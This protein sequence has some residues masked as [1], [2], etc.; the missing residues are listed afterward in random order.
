[1]LKLFSSIF[2]A[3]VALASCSQA[4]VVNATYN[5][6]A[7]IPV[8][9]S[10]YTATGNTV[11][12][13]LGFAPTAGTNLTV[14]NNT[15]L[16]FISGTFGN[17]MHGQA[18]TLSY[19]GATYPFVANYYG[20]TGNDLVLQWALQDLVT[21]GSN[22]E[23]ELGN[24]SNASNR[25]PGTV[26]ASGV[27]S[28]KTV[29]AIAAGSGPN[30]ALCSDGTLAAWGPNVFGN[31][32]NGTATNSNVPV[33][34]IQN[35]VLSGKTVIAIA[36]GYR[37]SVALCSDGTV[38]SW[39]EG[40]DGQLG[41]GGTSRQSQPV[42]VIRTGALSGKTVVAIAA[43]ARYSLAL[44]SD[45][46]LAGWGSNSSG[47]I[48][49]SAGYSTRVPVT[50]APVGALD[51][52]SV[53]A[54]AAG[55]SHSLA[56]CSDGT[57]AAWGYNDLGQ[58]GNGSFTRNS[59]VYIPAAVVRSGV[60]AGRTTVGIAA[61]DYH[62]FTWCSDGTI[63]AWGYN[64]DGEL[65]NGVSNYSSLMPVTVVQNG[66]LAGKTI[67]S[68]AGR[69]HNLALY[70]D[71]TLASW[72][73]NYS[74]QL[75]RSGSGL[76]PAAVTPN[77]ALAGK[78]VVSVAAGNSHSL[79]MA[80]FSAPVL[81]S[82]ATSTAI[83]DTAVTLGGNVASDGGRSITERGF[84]LSPT[85]VN[86]D[87]QIGGAGVITIK[88]SGT[89]GI[90]TLRVAD[91]AGA[92]GYSFKAY[93]TNSVGTTYTSPV[94]N[95]TTLAAD[96]S[97]SLSASPTPVPVG[98]DLTYSMTLT[99]NGPNPSGSPGVRLPLPAG[100]TFVSASAPSGWTI[101][102]PTV[103]TNGTV[104]FNAASLASGGSATFTVVAKVNLSDS[105]LSAT[106][107]SSESTTDPVP[108]NNSATTTAT[109]G[110][111]LV[112]SLSATPEP[113]IAGT[114][115][116]YILQVE[117]RGSLAVH[118]AALSFTLPAR[119][120]F[121]SLATS[122]GW[123]ATTPAVGATGTVSITNSLFAAAGNVSFPLV[124]KVGSDGDNGGVLNAALEASWTAN[125]PA[126]RN[127]RSSTVS[128]VSTVITRSD[129]AIKLTATPAIVK[130]GSDVNYTL[131]LTNNGPSDAVQ[132]FVSFPIPAQMTFV[133]AAIPVGW[134][135]TI[136]AIGSSGTVTF[137]KT[138][139][140]SG[141]VASFTIVAK[142][143]TATPTGTVLTTTAS[144]SATG[145]DPVTA[146]NNASA[147]VAVGTVKPTPLQLATTG[148]LNPQNGLYEL[149]VKVTNTTPLPINGFRLHV[150]FASYLTA[151]PS[152]RLH[153]ASSAAGSSDVY[154]NYPYAVA[155]D[156]VVPVKLSFYT[157]TRTFPKPFAP[158]LTV[159]ILPTSAV[160]HTNGTGVQPRFIR[161]NADN[162][163]IEF[164]SIPG[165]SYRVRYSH[166]LVHWFDCPV[167]ILAVNSRT[168]WIDNGAP[169]TCSPPSSVSSRYYRVNDITVPAP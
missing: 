160:A 133:T 128:T 156:G 141:S 31:L 64:S 22:G 167:P 115:L 152:L 83:A 84:V 68:I 78:T 6:A 21:W 149:T 32:G 39:G 72:G 134:T 62:S 140:T 46:T 125:D 20:G 143:R 36:A 7:T 108:G 27:L 81:A 122:N 79:V 17:L 142:V 41:D 14:I 88:A 30:M 44:C 28:G 124:V 148:T 99:N 5:T 87:P 54:I 70:T 34:V 100:T 18:V 120:T 43:G 51:G 49:S 145:I 112:A 89:T 168:Q 116:T 12:F 130:K 123:T 86:A 98:T 53:I 2:I 63:A 131:T 80:A 23:G 105:T 117:N 93:A 159:E 147:I 58:V 166:D 50:V 158:V 69:F 90:F 35:G 96:L 59:G 66:V 16:D 82:P 129:L 113:V 151:Y 138:G 94:S 75:G 38:A 24:G 45:G 109:T 56:L 1:M 8:V 52:K 169:F 55:A 73:Q 150:N 40:E 101:V 60:L 126:P 85:A 135:R 9:A 102:N 111:A 4:L 127:E 91:L 48:T 19:N 107:T 10:S 121:V 153:N 137:S 144:A 74:G 37:H 47:Q 164:P 118:N 57:L 157:R 165:H 65:G 29:I 163:L 13:T 110:N 106:A 33:A 162:A 67:R 92:T 114:E 155:V 3:S 104:S 154:V 76:S 77:G 132:P 25:V 42:A 119:T 11:N 71:G 139:L 103:G 136:P 26:T 97:I 161:L 61:G 15:G 95:F 146:N